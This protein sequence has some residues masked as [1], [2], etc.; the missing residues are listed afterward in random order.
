MLYFIGG[1]SIPF[2]LSRLDQ[3]IK[4]TSNCLIFDLFYIHS[5]KFQN[6]GTV[7]FQFCDTLDLSIIII[8]NNGCID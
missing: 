7:K 8:M 5:F 6:I 1:G 2:A 3:L 4:N